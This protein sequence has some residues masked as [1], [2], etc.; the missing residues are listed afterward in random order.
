MG[1][2]IDTTALGPDPR[3]LE[4]NGVSLGSSSSPVDLKI[5][6][7]TKDIVCD[8]LG[9]EVID[10]IN[11]GVNFEVTTTLKEVTVAL[12]KS[13]TEAIAVSEIPGVCSLPE[14]TDQA[15]CELA[16]ETWTPGTEVLGF[17]T[18][19]IGTNY[20]SIAQKLVARPLNAA[21]DDYSDDWCFWKAYPV[22]EGITFSGNDDLEL[23][24][25]FKIIAD[26]TKPKAV[27]KV[28]KGDHTQYA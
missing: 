25:T 5:E 1:L 6:T 27:S 8:Q 7:K 9:E 21:D 14:H 11:T 3:Y 19:K 28:V 2:V 15:A 13:M 24:V 16:T 12:L 18:S 22:I 4:F 17:G 26:T 20:S 23:P 10:T